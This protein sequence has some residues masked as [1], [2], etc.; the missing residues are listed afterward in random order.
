MF[1]AW[2]EDPPHPLTFVNEYIGT[3]SAAWGI[4]HNNPAAQFP[5]APLR[6]GPDTAQDMVHIPWN[7]FGGYYYRDGHIRAFSHTHVVG[8]GLPDYGNFGV[9]PLSV[10]APTNDTITRYGYRS[11]FSHESEKI[12][13]GFYTVYLDVP[14]ARAELTV[15]G[16]KQSKRTFV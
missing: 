5:F 6:L 9:M 10:A 13:P 1:Q 15:A 2:D 7:H 14:Q 8:A 11:T 16:A 4:G 3:G 12:F